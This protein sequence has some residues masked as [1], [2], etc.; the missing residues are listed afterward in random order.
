MRRK[1]KQGIVFLLVAVLMSSLMVV[2]GGCGY[3]Y[4]EGDFKLIVEANTT[5]VSIGETIE[6]TVRLQNLSGR[7]RWLNW[8][9]CYFGIKVFFGGELVNYRYCCV[10]MD[11]PD[12]FGMIERDEI[13]DHFTFFWEA[14][15]G[16]KLYVTGDARFSVLANRARRGYTVPERSDNHTRIYIHSEK[17]SIT[18]LE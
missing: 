12:M 2:A 8:G 17:I 13:W 11:G 7:N 4:S 18:V 15:E 16:G 5:E 6:F 9:P 14:E 1:I 3:T 10:L